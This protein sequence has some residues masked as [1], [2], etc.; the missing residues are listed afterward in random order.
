MT[1]LRSRLSWI[2]VAW[3]VC[4]AAGLAAA[5]L[6][7]CCPASAGDD[8]CPLHAQSG[9]AAPDD[10]TP[11]RCTMRGTCGSAE[12]S[13]LS[14]VGGAAVLPSLTPVAVLSTFTLVTVHAAPAPSRVEL[15]D[16]PPP[17]A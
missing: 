10:S 1:G 4:Q 8:T 15:P 12:A 5:P 16:S 6:A 7:L 13:L 17:R 2:V 11:G 3:L 9:A 14:L